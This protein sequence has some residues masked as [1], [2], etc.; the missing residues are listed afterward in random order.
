MNPKQKKIIEIWTWAYRK[1]SKS[2]HE[3]HRST[4]CGKL[5]AWDKVKENY[6]L[7]LRADAV[8]VANKL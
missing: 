3:F 7:F 6:A 2:F 8:R 5:I 4:P 1:H